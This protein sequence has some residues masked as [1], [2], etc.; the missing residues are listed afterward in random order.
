MA[1]D[2]PLG[3]EL[4]AR[5]N[6]VAGDQ[7]RR[8]GRVAFSVAPDT[9]RASASRDGVTVASGIVVASRSIGPRAWELDFE[10]GSSWVVMANGCGCGG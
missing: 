4:R 2:V 1:L 5:V 6:V 8:L 9:L 3:E 10:D 7:R